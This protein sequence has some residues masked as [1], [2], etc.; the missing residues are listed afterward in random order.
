MTTI[1]TCRQVFE[2]CNPHKVTSLRQVW[3]GILRMSS[4]GTADDKAY[5]DVF[6]A[7][8]KM[9]VSF[10]RLAGLDRHFKDVIRRDSG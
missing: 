9:S 1:L 8:L 7:C 2:L 4:A 10:L 5:R 3:T 6:T